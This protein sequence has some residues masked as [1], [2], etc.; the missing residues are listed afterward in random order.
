VIGAYAPEEGKREETNSTYKI[1]QKLLDK[2]NKSY[3]VLL[4]G[5]VNRR[6]GNQQVLGMVGTFGEESINEKVV[7][8]LELADFNE[9]KIMK[10][11]FRKKIFISIHGMLEV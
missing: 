1:I 4:I 2:Y 6:V 7:K 5:D 11:F 8:L 3:S 10:S 9:L